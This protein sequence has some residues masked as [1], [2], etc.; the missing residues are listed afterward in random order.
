MNNY[1]LARLIVD[2]IMKKVNGSGQVFYMEYVGSVEAL[3]NKHATQQLHAL[4]P[5]RC[6][7]EGCNKP[8]VMFYCEDHAP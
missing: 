5:L 6:E 4:D 8:A 7:E 3:L 1:E 2:N